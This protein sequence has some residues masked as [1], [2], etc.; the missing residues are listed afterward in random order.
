MIVTDSVM[1]RR[2]GWSVLRAYVLYRL[3]LATL[4]LGIT[5]AELA[6]KLFGAEDPRLY[7]WTIGS[8][9]GLLAT[10]FLLSYLRRPD[11]IVQATLHAGLDIVVFTA[12]MY[13][14]GG[15]SGSLGAL[16]VSAIA[17]SAILL[18][19]RLVITV[20]AAAA[21]AIIGVWLYGIW[22]SFA[23]RTGA[24]YL[25]LDLLP[26]LVDWALV[27]GAS[28]G[29][30]ALI[31]LALAAA[32]AAAYTIAERTRN[33][34]TLVLE[35]TQELLEMAELNAAIIRHLQS[36]I[37]V[38]DRHA[39]VKLMN[40]MAAELLDFHE[41]PIGLPLSDI[42]PL[43]SQRLGAWIGSGLTQTQPFRPA[44]HLPELIPEFT[45][46]S[47]NLAFETLV[48]IE[49]SNAA[50][51]RLQQIKLAALGRLTA[52]IAHEIRNP[53]ASIS[54]AAQ[55]LVEST[56]NPGEKRLGKIIHDNAGRAN[57]IIANVLDLSRRDKA[58]PE[59]IHLRSWLEDFCHD[60]MRGRGDPMPEMEIRVQP[61][62]LTVHFDAGHLQQVLWNL[63]NNACEHGTLPGES[64][65]VRIL[66]ALDPERFR[67]YIDVIDFGAG[68]P[69][70]EARQIFE[71][72]FTTN[73]KGTG[74]GLYLSREMCEANRAQLQYRPNPSG[75]GS[76]FRLTLPTATRTPA[77]TMNTT[78]EPTWNLAGR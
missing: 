76:C 56:A 43:L 19:R 62:D 8:Y 73:P 42:S 33:S 38:V 72:F 13:A 30:T 75:Q 59:D 18:P 5:L 24:P 16:L 3:V 23:L 51:A 11:L 34:E 21:L 52:S 36:G 25:S 6:G 32:A 54:H 37:L 67:P 70:A 63:C 78:E 1:D 20:T 2:R 15:A 57:Q 46:L 12:L 27:H 9:F 58:S 65:R 77:T 7:W 4:L 68:I 47:G 40:Q 31:C 29:Q 39:R 44:E 10:G 50:A 22:Q 41:R 14:S 55:L 60:F 53:L 17:G 64:P 61:E 26:P 45:A 49:D 71:P 48:F 35:R 74:L 28:G 66:A 69:E